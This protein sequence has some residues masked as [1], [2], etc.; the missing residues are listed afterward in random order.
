M[1]STKRTASKARALRAAVKAVKPQRA[2]AVKT[3]LTF[4]TFD[5][6]HVGHLRM[7]ER[8]R[9]LGT[10]LVVG[11]SSD[12]LNFSKKNKYPV[13]TQDER[14]EIM[15]GLKCV[16]AVFLEESLAEKADY[17][18]RYKAD[19]LVMGDDWKGKF[20]WVEPIAKCKVVYLTRTP[21]IS[22][23]AIVEKIQTG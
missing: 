15:R 21:A 4:G 13:F 12:A 5:L 16:D 7:L 20:D 22:T 18:L 14:L 19:V 6:F 8:A 1:T 9:A 17:A 11:V 10:R 3:V 23:T 2:R